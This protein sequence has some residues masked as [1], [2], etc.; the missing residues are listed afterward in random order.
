LQRFDYEPAKLHAG[1]EKKDNNRSDTKSVD[2]ILI[3]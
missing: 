2:K 1:R 3:K